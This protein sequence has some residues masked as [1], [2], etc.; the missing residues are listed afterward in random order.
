MM[1]GNPEAI[2]QQVRGEEKRAEQLM[3]S[4]KKKCLEIE[5]SFLHHC[6]HMG[7]QYCQMLVFCSPGRKGNMIFCYYLRLSFESVD[8]SIPIFSPQELRVR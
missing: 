3:E 7:Q 2:E 8:F 1:P 6:K 5:V 4:F